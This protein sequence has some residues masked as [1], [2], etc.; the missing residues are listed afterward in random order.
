MVKTTIAFDYHCQLIS[1]CVDSSL[2]LDYP[3]T[4]TSLHCIT[5]RYDNIR[6][7]GLGN[8]R[9]DVGYEFDFCDHLY[10]LLQL[11]GVTKY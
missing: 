11:I 5:F 9:V 6:V 1:V 8:I 3:G 7:V 10:V 4:L 2:R